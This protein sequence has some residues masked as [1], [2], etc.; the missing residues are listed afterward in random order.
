MLWLQV[1]PAPNSTGHYLID[2][3]CQDKQLDHYNRMKPD[4]EACKV[5]HVMRPLAID[6][7][8]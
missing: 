4:E 7:C 2:S 6:P 5:Q 3:S 8:C 1:L